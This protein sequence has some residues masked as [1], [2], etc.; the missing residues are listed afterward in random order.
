M[1][2][3]VALFATASASAQTLCDGTTGALRQLNGPELSRE[4]TKQL[5][6]GRYECA[7][8]EV[9]EESVGRSSLEGLAG[10]D[11]RF[12]LREAV[13][14]V[15]VNSRPASPERMALLKATV[16]AS[17]SG[18]I[19]R[20]PEDLQADV[21]LIMLSLDVPPRPDCA[22][23]F[24]TVVLAAHVDQRAP[25]ALRDAG[26]A[27]A[28]S[29][30]FPCGAGEGFFGIDQFADM[31][32][33]TRGDAQLAGWRY[34]L[35]YFLAYYLGPIGGTPGEQ[36][37][38]AHKLVE[39]LGNLSD[40]TMCRSGC[41]PWQWRPMWHAFQVFHRFGDPE[42]RAA[43]ERVLAMLDTMPDDTGKLGA[44]Q[45]ICRDMMFEHFGESEYGPVSKQV[46]L[47][48]SSIAFSGLPLNTPP[49]PTEPCQ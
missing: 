34:N 47:L 21:R 42:S 43:K 5:A 40:V 16:T 35:A 33:V 17:L 31:E 22:D 28:T 15:L 7:Q 11:S 49:N 12:A 46:K 29:A 1:L 2:W 30:L 18:S 32:R 13:L 23:R 48:E 8:S 39:L 6:A 27:T 10:W 4:L 9:S 44:F 24:E 3:L 45:E 14:E 19:H 20:R 38:Q 36:Q 26:V 37:L 41:Y 25:A